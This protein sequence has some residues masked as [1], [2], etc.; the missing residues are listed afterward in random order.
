MSV[1][2]ELEHDGEG[3]PSPSGPAAA[4][5]AVLGLREAVHDVGTGGAG[6]SRKKTKRSGGKSGTG[7]T[8]VKTNEM[9]ASD[10]AEVLM[11]TITVETPLQEKA[12]A[13]AVAALR[14]ME[15]GHADVRP[16]VRGKWTLHDDGSGTC[17]EC[18]I[19]QMLVWDDD[20]WM[21]YCGNCGAL[22][23]GES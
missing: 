10:A 4:E 21:N 7:G 8:T 14:E 3:E 9:T 13:M 16:V 5:T 6:G 15:E 19:R 12:V 1:V 18:G 17:S 22:M 20:G 11:R 2:R 23:E